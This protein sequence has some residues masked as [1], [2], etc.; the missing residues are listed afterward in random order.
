[1]EILW[2]KEIETNAERQEGRPALYAQV[3]LL[4]CDELNELKFNERQS[5]GMATREEQRAS[6]RE[7]ILACSLDLFIRRGYAAT[8]I[9]DIARAADMSI[10]LLFHYFDSKQGLYEALIRRGL[11][12]TKLVMQLDRSDPIA[13]FER[14]A[15]LI[16]QSVSTDPVS[17]KMF[18]LM[19]Q[20]MYDEAASPA[21]KELLRQVDNVEACVAL[22]ERGQRMGSIRQGIPLALSLAYWNAIQGIAQA[23]ALRPSD[24]CPQAEWIVD[25]LRAS[26]G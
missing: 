12:S 22:I 5:G 10:G 26:K 21:V 8:K 19:G 2:A 15:T 11:S 14:V 18:V 7:Q 3:R 20:A 9:A 13:F 24:P 4:F 17:A 6:R 1:M 25:I 16:L 23:L